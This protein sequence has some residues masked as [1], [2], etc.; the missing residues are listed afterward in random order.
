MAPARGLRPLPRPRKQAFSTRCRRRDRPD[1]AARGED[2]AIEIARLLRPQGDPE[3][4]MKA[5]F[6]SPRSPSRVKHP[7]GTRLRSRRS[8][9]GQSGPAFPLGSDEVPVSQ[10]RPGPQPPSQPSQ[11]PIGPVRSRTGG[12]KPRDRGK[13]VP[14]RFAAS[15]LDRPVTPKKPETGRTAE[16]QQRTAEAPAGAT[17]LARGTQPSQLRSRN[18]KSPPNR[19]PA[20]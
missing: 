1:D 20:A 13:G 7:P 17:R 18:L 14:S 6:W 8:G 5:C 16:A 11:R 2:M 19:C 4:T 9:L 3:P 10:L 12:R 15:G